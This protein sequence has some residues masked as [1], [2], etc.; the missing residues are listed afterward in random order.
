MSSTAMPPSCRCDDK[1]L[2]PT[3]AN[4]LI[5]RPSGTGKERV[6]RAIHAASL[7]RFHRL[8]ATHSSTASLPMMICGVTD[9]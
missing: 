4:L 3:A 2:G 5:T 8:V 6:V 9:C 1:A 7:R